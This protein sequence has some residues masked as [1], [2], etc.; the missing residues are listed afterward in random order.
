MAS[1]RH[2]CRPREA[3]SDDESKV[4]EMDVFLDTMI[5]LHY[6]PLDELDL[7]RIVGT[8][9]VVVVVPRITLRELD[10]HKNIHTSRRVRRSVDG[11]APDG[12]AARSQ[13]P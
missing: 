8:D 2:C 6:R 7:P 1:G 10:R 4:L 3:R 12:H 5:L 11:A 13:T 9:Q